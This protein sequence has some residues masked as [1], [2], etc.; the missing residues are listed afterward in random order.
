MKF[1]FA[2]LAPIARMV[3]VFFFTLTLLSTNMFAQDT[4]SIGNPGTYVGDGNFNLLQVG[5]TIL[6]SYLTSLFPAAAKLKPYIRAAT[7]ALL[8][9][10]SFIIFKVGAINGETF[11]LILATFLPNFAY[12][13]ILWEG[14]KFLLGL[15]GIKLKSPET[16]PVGSK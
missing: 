3:F 5:L 13:G 8:V 15:V 2:H 16:V 6:L 9:T 4:I 1:K 14:L 12:S 11:A 7:V 10:G